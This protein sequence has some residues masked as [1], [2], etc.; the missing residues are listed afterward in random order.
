MSAG[1]QMGKSHLT[2]QVIDRLMRDL[3]NQP[4]S[5]LMLTEQTLHGAR[6]YCVQ[7]VGGSW[8]DMEAW[9]TSTFGPPGDVWPNQDFVWPEV[10]RWVQNNRKFWFRNAKDRDWFILKWSV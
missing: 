4:I 6:Y 3:N 7:P 1:R 9:T 8:L 10:P 5:D 2:Q